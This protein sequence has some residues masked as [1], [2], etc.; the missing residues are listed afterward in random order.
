MDWSPIFQGVTKSAEE[1]PEL[2]QHDRVVHLAKQGRFHFPKRTARPTQG[3][4]FAALHI[5]LDQVRRTLV[6]AKNKLVE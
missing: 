3:L 4:P 5:Q 6:P 1:C 2:V